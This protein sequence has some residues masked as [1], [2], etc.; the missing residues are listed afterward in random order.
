LAELSAQHDAIRATGAQVAALSVD[1]RERSEDAR[2]R[3]RLAFPLLCDPEHR[4]VEAWGLFDPSEK[5]GISRPAT[6]LIDPARR[7][8]FRSLDGVVTRI[9]A[10]EM[11]AYLRASA[12]GRPAPLP[13]RRAVIPRLTE[14]VRTALPAFSATVR[15]W[16]SR[17]QRDASRPEL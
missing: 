9:D 17:R 16:R 1:T 14:M 6:F 7:V 2:Q 5:G 4:V 12:G 8:R 15:G 11:L 13:R 3:S 10:S